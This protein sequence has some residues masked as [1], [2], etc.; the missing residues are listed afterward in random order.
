MAMTSATLFVTLLIGA[1]LTGCDNQTN[2]ADDAA[3]NLAPLVKTA[4]V[5]LSGAE[6]LGLSGVVRAHVEAPLAFQVGGRIT[7]RKVN[8]GQKVKAGDLLF[9]LDKRDLEQSVQM[10]QATLKAADL[11]LASASA[12]LLRHQQ[13]Q[14]RNFISTQALERSSLGV[15]EAQTRKDVALAHL[16]Q[17]RNG[18]GYGALHSPSGGVLV[19]V[20]AEAGQVVGAGQTV[21]IL[22]QTDARDVEVSF[23]E[24]MRPPTRG[25]VLLAGGN[26]AITFREQAGALEPVGRTLRARYSLPAAADALLLGSVV[27]T[28]FST[29]ARA[30]Q[31]FNVPLSALN[32]RGAGPCVWLLLDGQVSAVPVTVLTM[33]SEKAQVSGP[34]TQGDHIVALGTHLLSEQMHVRELNP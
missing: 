26:V 32:E 23:P 10:A 22:A 6:V 1:L 13:L 25:E 21:A 33:D 18:F 7:A 34:L 14:A 4:R 16:G 24:Q 2:P 17:A 12:D 15:R 29:T 31:V 5:E 11:A 20:S 8:A 30:G 19:E 28:R 9:E 27:R 3:A